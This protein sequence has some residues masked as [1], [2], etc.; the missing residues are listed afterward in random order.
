MRKLNSLINR[1][2]G[3]LIGFPYMFLIFLV[4]TQTGAITLENRNTFAFQEQTAWE[5]FSPPDKS[6]EIE[7]PE[8]PKSLEN[9]ASDVDVS[10]L[11]TVFKCT[12]PLGVYHSQSEDDDSKPQFGIGVFEVTGCKRTKKMFQKEVD[13]LFLTWGGD[14]RKALRNSK[15]RVNGL[16]GRELVYE[17]GG[18]HGR[19]LFVNGGNRIFL[20]TYTKPMNLSISSDEEERIFRTFRP[21]AL[22]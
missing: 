4:I 14:A 8:R 17:I 5:V 12:K 20:L 19:V 10:I 9:P 18:S 16:E 3:K 21:K 7:L 1:I 11:L 13:M 2:R 15:V 22:K 6:F